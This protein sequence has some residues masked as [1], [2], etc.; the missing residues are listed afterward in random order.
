[1][2]FLDLIADWAKSLEG[3]ISALLDGLGQRLRAAE[4]ELLRMLLRDVLPKLDVAPDGKIKSTARN[5]ARLNLIDDVMRRF[6]GDQ[7]KDLT[8]ALASELLEVAGMNAEYYIL[9]GFDKAKVDAIAADT[10]IV[11]AIIGIDDAGNAIPDG[12]LAR[13]TK[14]D[15]IRG[16]IRDYMVRA[17]ASQTPPKEIAD[18]LKGLV[19]GSKEEDGVIRGYWRQ[20]AYDSYN[21]VREVSNLHVANELKLNA[22]VY[23]GGIIKASRPFCV[24]KNRKVFTR[25]EANEWRS[26]PDLIDKATARAYNPLIERGRYNCRHFLMWISD[27]R[28]KELRP[29]IKL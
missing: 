8:G 28:A 4:R 22:F 14:S 27:E 15:E 23:M 7:A 3:K 13:L 21:Q 6:A 26:D 20:Y 18:G 17:M 5:I 10:R 2:N 19:E 25:A 29:D 9:A 24:K 16:K 1:M 11:R 12:Y